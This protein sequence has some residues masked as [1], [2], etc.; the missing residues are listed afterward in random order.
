MMRPSR[1]AHLTPA[2]QAAWQ[3]LAALLEGMGVLTEADGHALESLC[4]TYAEILSL[5]AVLAKR[6]THT[7]ESMTD[8]GIMIR[9]YPEVA[10]LAAADRRFRAWLVEFGLTPAARSKV[11]IHED[12]PDDNLAKYFAH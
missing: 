4:E 8:A 2:A 6:G 5:R 11:S 1:P 12:E 9:A 3:S 7:Y 10:M